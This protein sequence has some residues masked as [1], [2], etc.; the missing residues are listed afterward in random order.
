LDVGDGLKAALFH[1]VAGNSVADAS[2]LMWQTFISLV[3]AILFR[4]RLAIASAFFSP[5]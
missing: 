5:G 1:N 4:A 2:A 3:S